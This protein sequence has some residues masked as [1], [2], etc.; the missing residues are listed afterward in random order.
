MSV[1]SITY[2][3]G[4]GGY[5]EDTYDDEP[6]EDDSG[7]IDERACEC[8]QHGGEECCECGQPLCG[9][10]FECGCGFCSECPTE[11]FNPEP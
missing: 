10:C 2:P 4:D 6:D 5:D 11:N 1:R 9:M 8:G 7:V 3:D